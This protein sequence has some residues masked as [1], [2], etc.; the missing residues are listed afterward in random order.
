MVQ[1]GEAFNPR[2]AEQ[3]HMNGEGQTAKARICTNIRG[4]FLAANMLLARGERQHKAAVA[5]GIH[6]FAANAARHLPHEFLAAGKEADMRPAK[7]Q[8]DAETLAFADNNICALFARRGNRRER[9]R[10]SEDRNEQRL[11]LIHI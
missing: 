4:R 1:C 2:I 10:F 7:G 6:G 5:I 8:P 11:S 3:A 9:D